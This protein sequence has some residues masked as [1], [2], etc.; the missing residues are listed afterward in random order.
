MDGSAIE[1]LIEGAVGD[2]RAIVWRRALQTQVAAAVAEKLPA[3]ETRAR[4]LALLKA[5]LA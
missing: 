5:A 3:Q 4:V 1:A 2:R